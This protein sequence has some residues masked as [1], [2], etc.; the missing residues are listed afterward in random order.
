MQKMRM[1]R[2]PPLSLV[3]LTLSACLCI[4]PVE[5]PHCMLPGTFD[6]H[7]ALQYPHFQS[8][9]RYEVFVVV[10][11][12]SNERPLVVA[13]N[14]PIRKCFILSSSFHSKTT[15]SSVDRASLSRL[16]NGTS[17]QRALALAFH[18]PIQICFTL[19][20][21]RSSAHSKS[22][23]S[24][25]DRVSLSMLVYGTSNQRALAMALHDPIQICV[26]PSSS[27]HSKS[28]E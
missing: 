22:T 15:Q 10:H 26:T 2:D 21:L 9:A 28:I 3:G 18:D 14:D 8:P 1:H 24:T 4:V 11:G 16:V 20:G 7:N 25:V 12:T 5:L 17:N 27:V 19:S 23:Q 6:N 13:S